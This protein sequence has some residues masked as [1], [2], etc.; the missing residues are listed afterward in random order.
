[1]RF[2]TI[3]SIFVAICYVS[4]TAS[5][6]QS[7]TAI[8]EAFSIEYPSSS[9]FRDKSGR[10][11]RVYGQPFSIGVSAT[12]SADRFVQEWSGIWG[13]E[14]GD[15]LPLGPWGRGNHL[16]PIMYQP[17]I[18]T[19]KFTGVGYTQSVDGIP[20]Y[21][22]RLTVLVRN[23][24]NFP[25]VHVTAALHDL[26]EWQLPKTRTHDSIVA[27]PISRAMGN[28]VSLTKPALFVFVDKTSKPTLA[29]ITEASS[30]NKADGTFEKQLFVIDAINGNVLHVEDRIIYEIDGTVSALATQNS[31][32]DEC[33]DELSEPMPYAIISGGGESVY[34]DADGYFVLPTSGPDNVT[35]T[36]AIEG[37]WFSVNNQ[38][39]SDS[40]LSIET[41]PTGSADF[42]HNLENIDELYRAEVNAYIE[43]NEVRDFVLNY[44]PDFPKIATQQNWPVNVNINDSC[45]AFYDYS[46][47]NFYRASGGCNNTAFSDVVHHEY[48]H[49]LV[50]VGGS[51]QGEYGE[52][53]GDVMGVLITGDNIL[54]R[55]FYQG[56]CAGG[57]RNADNTCQYSETNCSSCGNEIHACGQLISGC[58]WDIREQLLWQ[59]PNGNDIIS[60]LAVNSIL[61]HNG[62]GIDAAIP[63]DYLTLDDDDSDLENGTPHYTQIA[64][65]FNN[66]G[67]FVPQITFLT[68]ELTNEL[69]SHFNPAGG[70]EVILSITNSVGEYQANT[71]SIFFTA[72]D[73]IVDLYPMTDLGDETFSFIVPAVPCFN[74]ASFWFTA[75][76]T[77]N[78]IMFYPETAPDGR[79]YVVSADDYNIAIDDDFETD[80]GWTVTG[81][82]NAPWERGVPQDQGGNWIP[83][84]DYDGSGQCYVTGNQGS[85]GGNDLDGTTILTS[86]MLDASSGG[87]LSW[88]YWLS[89]RQNNPH[90][91]EDSF[92]L[93]ASTDNGETWSVIR[94]YTEYLSQGG[95]RTDELVV[96]EGALIEPSPT[97]QLRFYASDLSPDD[98]IEAGVD[99]VKLVAIVCDEIDCVGDINGDATVDV[100]DLLA[101]VADWNSG[102]GPADVNGDG[103]VDIADLLAVIN[104]WGQ[105]P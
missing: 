16:Q 1:M 21:G 49:H 31:G 62:S 44:N 32:A 60:S 10:I 34:A 71:A 50:A 4:Q 82:S 75:E 105:C 94:D 22:S 2:I 53:M 101:V 61:L 74:E 25:A 14:E 68:M 88:A 52:G 11:T 99:A 91:P 23:E 73:G 20:V 27:R 64:N 36:S 100:G 29:Y 45:N 28:Q 8:S 59:F 7:N 86:P 77:N 5:A 51:G 57:L 19:Y 102:P 47:I 80:Q 103:E 70:Y 42:L 104:G 54:G 58:V 24:S 84:E 92:Q 87:T 41:P 93:Q 33:Q 67:I 66:H 69:P 98:R 37:Q 85:G 72:G 96:E 40:S 13:C 95:W 35:V 18:G 65:G 30:G 81:D 12:D 90:G 79:F 6:Q 46:S 97:L 55:G 89:E 78:Q 38:A 9:Y 63:I 17:E 76:T 26:N 39:A 83:H 3:L 48:G 56:N 43:S 15:F